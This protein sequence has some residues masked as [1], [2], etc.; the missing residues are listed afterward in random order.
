MMQT[1]VKNKYMNATGA[2]GIGTTRVKSICIIATG[3]GGSVVMA[4]G[5][6]GTTR[7]Q[8]D[9]DTTSGTTYMLFPGEGVK[10]ANDPYV[11]LVNVAS[12]SFF[13]G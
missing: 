12:V 13:Y 6:G 4:D 2:A 9:S 5:Q 11:T 7:I 3:T 1:D 8:L 10:F